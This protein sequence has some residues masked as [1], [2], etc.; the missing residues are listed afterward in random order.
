MVSAM[1][2]TI[3]FLGTKFAMAINLLDNFIS[4]FLSIGIIKDSQLGESLII[5]ESPLIFYFY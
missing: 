5:Q 3:E 4:S 2:A 1:S